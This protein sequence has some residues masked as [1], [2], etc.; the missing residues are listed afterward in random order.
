MVVCYIGL[1]SNLGDRKKYLQEAVKRL[2]TLHGTRVRKVSSFIETSPQGGPGGQG[3]YLN[4][5]A[6]IET[7]LMPYQL[8]QELQHIEH[9]L[10]RIRTV[11]NGPRT[12]DLDILTYGDI[13]LREEALCIPHPAMLEREFVLVPLREIA[14][15]AVPA[16]KK[17]ISSRRKRSARKRK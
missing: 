3:L 6:E 15:E 14:P 8:L 5:V 11:I 4:A 16:V 12:I 7:G 9:A 17:M 10:G 13:R 2:K 1:G